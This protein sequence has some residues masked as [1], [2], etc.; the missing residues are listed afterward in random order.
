MR[1]SGLTSIAPNF[2]KSTSGTFGSP[3]PGAAAPG[4]AASAFFTQDF[5][6]SGVMRSLTPV[7]LMLARSTPSS[8]A[9]L[10]TD[11]LACARAKPASSIAAAAGARFAGAS[12]RAGGSGAGAAGSSRFASCFGGGAGAGFAAAASVGAAAFCGFPAAAPSTCAI[13]L[14]F[15]TR[16]PF[17]SASDL[18]TPADVDGT[19]IVAFSVSSVISGVSTAMVSPGFTSTSMTSTSLKSPRSG[20][21]MS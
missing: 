6:S 15:E 3:A 17:L 12:A 16:S 19:S 8:R 7:P 9:N 2:E 5:T 18:M 20:T 1:P 13:R 4:P 14:P 11:G 21:V 10:R